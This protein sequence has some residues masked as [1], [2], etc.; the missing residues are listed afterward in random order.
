MREVLAYP[1]TALRIPTEPVKE[2]NDEIASLIKDMR[3]ITRQGHVLGLAANQIGE[4]K[5]ILIAQDMV[6]INPVI[7]KKYGKIAIKEGCLSF[8][9]L[10]VKVERSR[11]IVVHCL[12][13]E[14]KLLEVELTNLDAIVV[15]H[16][17]DHL[18]GLTFLDKVMPFK[19]KLIWRK[20]QKHLGKK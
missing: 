15:Q 16:E 9:G 3:E 10:E 20:Y 14:G 1:H 8:P 4:R 13:E 5:S 12:S 19:R 6:Y 2:I 18:R 11:E 17:I 7:K